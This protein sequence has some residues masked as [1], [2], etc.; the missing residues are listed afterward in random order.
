MSQKCQRTAERAH[1]GVH[2]EGAH[3]APA[4]PPPPACDLRVLAIL[5][6]SRRVRLLPHTGQLTAVDAAL[7]RTIASN[8]DLHLAQRKSYIGMECSFG[9]LG[10]LSVVNG[11]DHLHRAT[12][13]W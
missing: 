12:R 4:S 7:A 11:R 13:C 10:D 5:D 9:P 1:A 3:D 8:C 2:P 6:T